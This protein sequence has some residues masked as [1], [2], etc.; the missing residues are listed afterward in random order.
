MVTAIPVAGTPIV[1]WLWGGY[2]V[3]KCGIRSYIFS[4]IFSLNADPKAGSKIESNYNLFDDCA[5]SKNLNDL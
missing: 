3:A 5:G 4:C 2:T 1:Q